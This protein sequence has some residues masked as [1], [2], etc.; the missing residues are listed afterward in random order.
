MRISFRHA[1][2]AMAA[3]FVRRD[4]FA[5]EPPREVHD[6]IDVCPLATTDSMP[7]LPGVYDPQGDYQ[8]PVTS[9][10]FFFPILR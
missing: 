9:L 8:R 1:I 3:R 7:A 4:V 10:N 2:I 6:P 5:A